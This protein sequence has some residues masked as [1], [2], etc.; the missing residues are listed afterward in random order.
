M[1][2][3]GDDDPYDYGNCYTNKVIGRKDHRGVVKLA[4]TEPKTSARKKVAFMDSDDSDDV[5]F[6]RK[7]P[8]GEPKRN[9]P[10]SK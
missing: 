10:E 4:T 7:K 5:L 2:M 6:I 3:F 8:K 1:G 9:I